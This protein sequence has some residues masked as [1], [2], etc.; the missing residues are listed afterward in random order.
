MSRNPQRYDIGIGLS[1]FQDYYRYCETTLAIQP[2]EMPWRVQGFGQRK[3]RSLQKMVQKWN[4]FCA[5]QECTCIRVPES[6]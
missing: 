5:E 3:N 6:R 4:E 2:G 1:D